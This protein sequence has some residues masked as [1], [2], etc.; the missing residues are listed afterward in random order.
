VGPWTAGCL[1]ELSEVHISGGEAG[2][3][4]AVQTHSAAAFR[5]VSTVHQQTSVADE[6][7]RKDKRFLTGN[8][9]S[10][11]WSVSVVAPWDIKP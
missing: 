7:R 1:F 4:S 6:K 10:F 8:T 9:G 3:K 5:D 11:Y 2:N